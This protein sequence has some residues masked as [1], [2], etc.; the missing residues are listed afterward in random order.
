MRKII[1]IL[2]LLHSTFATAQ[3][4]EQCNIQIPVIEVKDSNFYLL[5]DNVL[6]K[7]AKC[8]Y[9]SDSMSYHLDVYDTH[10][11]GITYYYLVFTGEECMCMFLE[12]SDWYVGAIKYGRHYFFVSNW[13]KFSFGDLFVL[14]DKKYLF[15]Y[16]FENCSIS[17][18]DSHAVRDY[19]F[20][21]S[22][23]QFIESMNEKYRCA[24]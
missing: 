22:K 7:D 21:Q 19:W 3:Y 17:D 24:D 6:E 12:D 15:N 4:V 5:L 8:D 1:F 20:Y 14:T 13:R 11:K 18:D 23:Y 10:S 2:L 16:Y 9:F